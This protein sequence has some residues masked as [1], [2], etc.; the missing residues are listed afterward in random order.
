[1]RRFFY[2]VILILSVNLAYG[3]VVH[4][5]DSATIGPP[6]AKA[7]AVKVKVDTSDDVHVRAFDQ[8]A[9]SKYAENPEFKYKGPVVGQSWLDRFFAW[10]RDKL[11]HLFTF[12]VGKDISW[13]GV[14]FNIIMLTLL[15]GGVLALIYFILK[16]GGIDLRDI[17]SRR[18]TATAVPYSEFFEDINAIDFDAEIENAVAKHNYRFAVRL[19]YLKSLKHLSDAGLIKWEIDKTNTQYI[20]ELQNADQR[21]EFGSLTRQFEYVW[22]GEFMIDNQIYDSIANSFRNFNRQKA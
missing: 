6:K 5:A 14:V 10:L 19:L 18:S 3:S 8:A 2:L 20:Y 13:L 4:K 15:I 9:L 16:A 11:A 12:T 21:T 22:Y 7:V 17:F 1:M